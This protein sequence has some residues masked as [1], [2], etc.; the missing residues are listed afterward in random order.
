[1]SAFKRRGK[2]F[3]GIIARPLLAA[4]ACWFFIFG[5]AEDP[6]LEPPG[7][8][9]PD[10]LG[11]FSP[12]PPQLVLREP[13]VSG[14]GGP[15]RMS[16]A[17]VS[18]DSATG[19]VRAY[20]AIRNTGANTIV[21]PDGVALFDFTSGAVLLGP[22]NP[23]ARVDAVQ[24]DVPTDACLL[25]YRGAFGMDGMLSPGEASALRLWVLGDSMQTAFTFHARVVDRGLAGAGEISG[26]V[27]E[28]RDGDGIR[29]ADEPGFANAYVAITE[30]DSVHYEQADASGRYTIRVGAPGEYRLES[31]FNGA[32]CPTTSPVL[33]V[34]I[35]AGPS[36]LT[37]YGRADFGAKSGP[38]YT[39]SV[40]FLDAR[41]V[42][43]PEIP[44]CYAAEP[45]TIPAGASFDVR[46]TGATD[47]CGSLAGL[48]WQAV[49]PGD[50]SPEPWQPFGVD[51]L[52]LGS[53]VDTTVISFLGDTLWTASAGVVK[54]RNLPNLPIARRSGNFSLRVRVRDSYGRV[55]LI[56]NRRLA[57]NYDPNT[58]MLR[59]PACDCPNPPPDCA[60]RGMVAAGWITGI[61]EVVFAD[62]TQWILFCEGDTLPQRAHVRF[63]ARGAD[64]P[65][66]APVTPPATQPVDFSYRYEWRTSLYD[67]RTQPYS[68]PYEPRAYTLPPPLGT[69]WQGGSIG[70]G[71]GYGG[72]CP[73][74]YT[75]YA[76]AV[77]EHEKRDGTPDSLQFYVGGS[78]SLGPVSTPRVVVLI[79]TCPLG[80]GGNCDPAPTFGTDTLAVP[81]TFIA[82]GSPFPLALGSS[83]FNV[84]IRALGHDH[85]R[86]RSTYYSSA[87]AGRIRSWNF[88][89]DCT[90][91]CEDLLLPGEGQWIQ[92]VQRSDPPG[93]QQF[94]EP[95]TMTIE[96]DTLCS[97]SPVCGS[98][99]RLV[100]SNAS[101]GTYRF[102]LQGRDTT[103]LGETCS[104]PSDL[105]PNPATFR[106]D[107]SE[108][109]RRTAIV[110]HD[111]VLRQLRDVRPGGG[112][113]QTSPFVHRAIR[114]E[115]R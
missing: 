99:F 57:L 9:D 42:G 15:L 51:S 29:D 50:I 112:T 49:W 94:D 39:P 58:E 109:G 61:D 108:I 77:D 63:Y 4:F 104:E 90:S 78:P 73:F 33:S 46:F 68:T 8:T 62:S 25:D 92:D 37:G 45:C 53:E 65:R 72:I 115:Q 88:T 105:G 19:W 27:F 48:Q 79:P 1:V 80:F 76:S 3:F 52:F 102:T 38:I 22:G 34:E 35:L 111:V 75:F 44:P 97:A 114:L 21:G 13:T 60:A 74:D 83:R 7:P 107:I 40:T 67:F 20:V 59:I 54:V 47:G 10:F 43:R 87:H 12:N 85:P 98:S 28:D 41:T 66:D 32:V 26:V 93:E 18:L 2:R 55:S 14:G 11:T 69:S 16:V 23:C 110:T 71:R 106:R 31:S 56:G 81:G 82:G 91:G 103:P 6:P 89:F 96:N 24:P 101:L 64:D 100:L 30:P 70:W 86:D 17:S 36:G 5:C 113:S 84:S 95:L